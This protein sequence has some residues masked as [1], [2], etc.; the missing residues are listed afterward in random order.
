MGGT[1]QARKPTYSEIAEAAGVSEATVSR[2]LNDDPKVHPDRA[3]AVRKAVEKLGYRRN[4]AAAALASGKTSLIAIVIEDDLGVFSDPF[5]A[6]VSSGIS[7]VLMREELQTMLLVTQTDLVDSPTARFL[8]RGEVDGAIFFQ[9]HEDN[10][11]RSL[12]KKGIPVV[13]T[14]QPF[15]PGAFVFVDSDNKD[16]GKIATDHLFKVG[17]KNVAIIT[18]DIAATAAR[19]RR[20]GYL[21]SCQNH[22]FKPPKS[23]IVNGNWSFDSGREEMLRLL[24]MKGRPDGIFAANDQMARG[25]IAAIEESGFDCPGEIKVVGFDDSTLAVAGRPQ[26]TT[27]RQ[28]IVGLGETAARLMVKLLDGQNPAPVILKTELVIRESA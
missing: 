28:D 12:A 21:E 14:G 4:R 22:G 24:A 10:L 7:K 8:D 19:N 25:A 5:W 11:V 15:T 17:C 13:M 1:H 3:K 16:G 18:G 20:D 23:F 6:T 2:V 27:V 9:M 26:L